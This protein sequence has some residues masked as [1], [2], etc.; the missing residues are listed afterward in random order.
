VNLRS[1]FLHSVN[2]YLCYNRSIDIFRCLK[3]SVDIFI[4]SI[5]NDLSCIKW[6]KMWHEN[7]FSLEKYFPWKM[8]FRRNHFPSNQTLPYYR[9]KKWLVLSH[10]LLPLMKRGWGQR[11]RR[12]KRKIRPLIIYF[13]ASF[14]P[15]RKG[16]ELWPRELSF[17]WTSVPS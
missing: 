7:Q 1:T 9:D 16:L 3:N 13:I 14:P 12:R 2:I 5:K 8:I 10:S 17:N 11:R 4:F 6:W 15:S